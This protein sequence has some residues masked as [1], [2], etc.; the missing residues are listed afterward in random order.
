MLNICI[1]ANIKTINMSLTALSM[2][3]GLGSQALQ[4]IN[5][6]QQ[7]KASSDIAKNN[8][9]PNYEIPEAVTESLNLSRRNASMTELPNQSTMEAR[10]GSTTSG[11]VG[12]G[13]KGADSQANLL[14]F[15]GKQ[16]SNQQEG[17]QNIG[18]QAAQQWN[19]NQVALKGDLNNYGAYQEKQWNLNKYEPYQVAAA[20]AAALQKAGTE[21]LVNSIGGVGGVLGQFGINQATN[22]YY[23][24]Q[25]ANQK[26]YIE[27]MIKRMGGGNGTQTSV[28]PVQDPNA[29][30]GFSSINPNYMDFKKIFGI[31]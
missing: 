14:D 12:Q 26:K 3:L 7:L 24:D 19:N 9:R 1:F 8:T 18:M 4:L 5:S 20:K 15:I 21:G 23:D 28:A 2:G 10:M 30:A 16:F 22:K 6:I 13:L 17:M 25:I 31:G 11:A 27:E 29:D